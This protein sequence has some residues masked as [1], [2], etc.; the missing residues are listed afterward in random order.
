M[1]SQLLSKEQN[2]KKYNAVL[3]GG[4]FDVLHK[5]HK[6]YIFQ[7]LS[8]ANK[9]Y[10]NLA[11]DTLATAS[12]KYKVKSYDI[13]KKQVKNY[14]NRLKFDNKEIIFNRVDSL[15]DVEKFCLRTDELDLVLASENNYLK[16]FR[17]Y[18]KKRR[19][20]KKTEFD[21]KK[22]ILVRDK[23]KTKI[24]SSTFKQLKCDSLRAVLKKIILFIRF[25]LYP[26]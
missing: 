4:T 22:I 6:N 2:V 12:K 10:I 19:E 18:N 7:G 8:K 25:R 11:S 9:L 23:N 24:S 15:K 14:I 17:G 16:L 3:I 20:E 1:K 13:R 26:L 21:V 5:G